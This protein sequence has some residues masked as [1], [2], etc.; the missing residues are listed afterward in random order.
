VILTHC[1]V[2]SPAHALYSITSHVQTRS[3]R[4]LYCYVILL[5]YHVTSNQAVHGPAS[6]RL[7]MP[8]ANPSQYLMATSSMR[9][10]H[11]R[12]TWN[13]F[14]TD[15]GYYA[16]RTVIYTNHHMSLRRWNK[17]G[18]DVFDKQFSTLVGKLLELWP[19]GKLRRSGQGSNDGTWMELAQDH[20][21]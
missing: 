4:S 18:Y 2:M 16:A 19:L 14:P 9:T 10:H 6:S 20:V 7:A 3:N 8:W 11:P 1:C 5:G 12:V 13:T 21:Q 17:K 15:F